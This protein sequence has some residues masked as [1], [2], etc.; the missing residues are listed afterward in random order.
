MA[1]GAAPGM[2]RWETKTWKEQGYVA[3]GV[4]EAELGV[5]FD[6]AALYY[7]A[8]PDAL[9]LSLREDLIQRAIDRRLARKAGQTEAAAERPWPGASLGLRVEREAVDVIRRLDEGHSGLSLRTAAWSTLPILTEW[10]LRYPD[11]DPL[12]VHERVFAVRL[13]TPAGGSFAWNDALKTMETSD[14]GSPAAPKAGPEMPAALA[15]FRRGEFGLT[16][17]GE[18]LRARAAL[19]RDGK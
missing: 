9:V 19:E 5:G 13:G 15:T 8:M 1:D 10:K 12:R 6:K 2:T 4:H 3:I 17:E 7:A 11:E 14:Y 18:G 16:F